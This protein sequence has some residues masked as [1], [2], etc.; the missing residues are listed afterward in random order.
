MSSPAVVLVKMNTYWLQDHGIRTFKYGTSPQVSTGTDVFW[1]EY[2]KQLVKHYT[3]YIPRVNLK[4]YCQLLS[5][6]SF[7]S[8]EHIFCLLE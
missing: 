8:S 4:L 1:H 6:T 7:N 2:S 5:T 3:S